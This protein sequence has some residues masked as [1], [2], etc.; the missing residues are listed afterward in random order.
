M[1]SDRSY[2]EKQLQNVYELA[3]QGVPDT[4]IAEK[5]G[6]KWSVVQKLTTRFWKERMKNKTP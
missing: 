2:T 5:I 1:R 6:L 4:E 3:Y